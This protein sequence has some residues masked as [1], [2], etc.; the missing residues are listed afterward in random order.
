MGLCL[1]QY[2]PTSKNTSSVFSIEKE[3]E[4]SLSI[5]DTFINLHV[6]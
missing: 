4:W 5:Y 2:L 3:I 6:D 1:D